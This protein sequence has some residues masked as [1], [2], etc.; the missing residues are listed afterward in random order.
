MHV[1]AIDGQIFIGDTMLVTRKNS[2]GVTCRFRATQGRFQFIA[3]PDYGPMAW[4]LGLRACS[5]FRVKG[6]LEV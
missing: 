1:V 5:R 3:R 2:W 6:M 4:G